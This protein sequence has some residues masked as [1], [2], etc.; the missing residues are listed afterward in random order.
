MVKP[1][2]VFILAGSHYG[3]NVELVQTVVRPLMITPLPFMPPYMEGLTNFRGDILPVINLNKRL[4]FLDNPTEKLARLIVLRS[5]NELVG[6][7]VD[8]VAGVWEVEEDEIEPPSSIVSSQDMDFLLGIVKK[9]DQLVFLLATEEMLRIERRKFRRRQIESGLIYSVEGQSTKFEGDCV[10]LAAGGLQLITERELAIG[11]RLI[12]Q[13]DLYHRDHWY[14]L[15]GRIKW[16]KKVIKQ[17]GIDLAYRYGIQFETIPLD[18]KQEI[19][20]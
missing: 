7:L 2:I 18:F 11:Q 6:F 12:L 20:P 1:Y 10:D 19:L 9:A 16:K 3:I 4:D 17:T 5:N 15:T 13:L 14:L 8:E